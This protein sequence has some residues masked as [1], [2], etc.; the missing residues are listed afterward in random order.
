M[1]SNGS[2]WNAILWEV[3]TGR[4]VCGWVGEGRAQRTRQKAFAVG[5]GFDLYIDAARFLPDH[6]TLSSV[7]AF[8]TDSSNNVYGRLSKEV[9]GGKGLRLKGLG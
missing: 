2:G 8:V 9:R 3:V 5:D 7:E 4:D 6:V 1:E